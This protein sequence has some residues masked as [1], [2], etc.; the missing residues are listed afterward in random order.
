MSTTPQTFNFPIEVHFTIS[1]DIARTSE[2]VLKDV[3]LPR[4]LQILLPISFGLQALTQLP[5]IMA[6]GNPAFALSLL[7][8]ISGFFVIMFWR[9]RRL[10]EKAHATM[11]GKGIIVRFFDDGLELGDAQ[12][13]QRIGY[14]AVTRVGRDDRGL[15]IVI[16]RLGG[17]FVPTH[18]FGSSECRDFVFSHLAN[19]MRRKT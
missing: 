4:W 10:K 18:A 11:L 12:A 6:G 7:A 15:V 16:R 1:E 9:R 14:G 19:L 3:L 5:K 8:V 2:S 13:G 17:L